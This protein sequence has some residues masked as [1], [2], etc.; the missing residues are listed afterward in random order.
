M[1]THIN[2]KNTGGRFDGTTVTLADGTVLGGI[3]DIKVYIK[4]GHPNS[5]EVTFLLPIIDID[6]EITV[7]KEHLTELA[8]THGFKLV[9]IEGD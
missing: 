6:A 4:S 8:K 2:I 1:H 3:G 5:A 9:K 7:S